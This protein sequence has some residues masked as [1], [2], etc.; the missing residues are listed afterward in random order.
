MCLMK[1]YWV[2]EEDYRGI[3]NYLCDVDK[4][5][6]IGYIDPPPM[7]DLKKYIYSMGRSLVTRIDGEIKG[8]VRIED[9]LDRFCTFTMRNICIEPD[10]F[11]ELMDY[12]YKIGRAR[13]HRYIEFIDVPGYMGGLIDRLRDYGFSVSRS[14]RKRYFLDGEYFDAYHGYIEVEGYEPYTYSGRDLYLTSIKTCVNI[15]LHTLKI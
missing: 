3:L 5:L 11:T 13:G 2:Y 7:D 12:I 10:I 8:L 4:A 14:F 1:T 9:G 15:T 6:S